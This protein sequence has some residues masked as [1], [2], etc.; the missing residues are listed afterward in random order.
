MIRKR[1]YAGIGEQV[2]YRMIEALVHL[3]T[4]GKIN[5]EEL[6]K[7]R[8]QLLTLD[9]NNPDYAEVNGNHRENMKLYWRLLIMVLSIGVDFL[10]S[11]QAMAIICDQF[12]LPRVLKFFT[13]MFLII[14]EIGISYFQA[15]ARRDG[16]HGPWIVRNAQYL[17]LLIMGG[18]TIL[19]IIFSIQSYNEAIDG[20]NLLSFII[21]T[22]LWQIALFVA[23]IMLHVWL[24]RNAEA[25]A[26][27]FA[28][29]SYKMNRNKLTRKIR[30]LEEFN[31][32]TFKQAFVID[33][34]QLVQKMQ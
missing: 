12:N 32:I 21:G 16:E 22:L 19:V 15:I 33:A 28:H 25:I 11:F 3:F 2:L 17:V 5:N 7:I 20:M 27:T 24:I 34:H 29:F 4:K 18:F 23:A 6:K 1:Y 14:V 31:Q 9:E 10:L 30:K 8:T 26:E 13:P